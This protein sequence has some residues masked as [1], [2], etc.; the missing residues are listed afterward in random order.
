MVQKPR[1]VCARAILPATPLLP[2]S[3]DEGGIHWVSNTEVVVLLKKDQRKVWYRVYLSGIRTELP[4]LK[5]LGTAQRETDV[6]LGKDEVWS[7]VSAET[8]KTSA[9]TSVILAA[10]ARPASLP[11]VDRLPGCKVPTDVGD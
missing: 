3:I 1:D 10:T 9:G 7:Y 2:M 4:Q 5:R 8:W 11:M 6:R